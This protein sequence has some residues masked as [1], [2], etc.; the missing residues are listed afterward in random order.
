MLQIN[1]VL[2][3]AQ[4]NIT[5]KARRIIHNFN[6]ICKYGKSNSPYCGSLQSYRMGLIE[7]EHLLS[8]L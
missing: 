3:D 6:L 5:I 8:N 2:D 1:I 4:S 7:N